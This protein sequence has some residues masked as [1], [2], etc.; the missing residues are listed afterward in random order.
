M[1]REIVPGIYDVTVREDANGRRY[2]VYLADDAE[3]ANRY[4]AEV[5]DGRSVVKSKSMTSEEIEV[6]DRLEAQGIDVVE[7]EIDGMFRDDDDPSW[8]GGFEFEDEIKGGD[9]PKEYIP[10][11]EKGIV[12]VMAEG[13][14]AHSPIVDLKVRLLEGSHHEVDSSERA[15]NKCAKKAFREAFTRGKPRLLEPVC[16]VMVTAPD[17]YSGAVSSSLSSRRARITSMEQ[18]GE[19][20]I[21]V[22]NAMVPLAEMFGY[23][24]ELRNLTAGRA[25]FDMRFEHYEPVPRN[26][27]DEIVERKREEAEQD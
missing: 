12:E 21:Q 26:I 27:A 9:I 6:N 5:V 17:E 18:R 2:R 8:L 25:E 13:I 20:N 1:P 15:F 7:T 3:D 22:V 11:V 4:I 23:S 10:S 16:S 24:S 19:R 14:Y